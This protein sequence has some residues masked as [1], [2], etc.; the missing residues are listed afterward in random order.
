V[1]I[2]LA[3]RAPAES[4]EA[5]LAAL[6]ELAPSGVEQVDGDGWVEYAVYGAPGELPALGRG[7]AEIAGIRVHVRGEEVPGDWAER[8]KRFHH[9]VLVGGRLWVRPPWEEPAVRPGATDLVVDPGAAFGTGTHPT[10][11]LCLEL[12]L[13]LE[14]S[15]SFADLGCGSGVLALAAAKL[16]FAPVAALDAERAALE[17]TL[18]NARANGVALDRVERFDL[19]GRPVPAAQ[20]VAANLMRPLLLRVAELMTEGPE[21]LIASG[22]LEHEADEVGAAFAPLR[23]RRRLSEAGWTALLL[24]RP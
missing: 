7:E 15:G 20:A 3:V 1:V 23:E 24:E 22:L 6:L 21:V 16:G 5:V 12:L 17:A 9:P 13:E 19:R 4:A 2:R 14:P 8:W 10:T 11:R 18:E